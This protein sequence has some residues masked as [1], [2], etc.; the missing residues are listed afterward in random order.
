MIIS[1]RILG[2][3]RILI[4]SAVFIV[5]NIIVLLIKAEW[6]YH[7]LVVGMQLLFYIKITFDKT[8][9]RDESK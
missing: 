7:W 6:Y 9:N 2:I 3:I 1:D 8:Y 5:P 4:N